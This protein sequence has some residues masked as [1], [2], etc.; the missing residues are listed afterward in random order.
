MKK[1]FLSSVGVMVLTIIHHIYGA[2][3]YNTAFRLHI[4]YFAIPVI[5]MLIFTY[6][7][8]QRRQT[9]WSGRI[10]FWLFVTI[11]LLIP[12]GGIGFIEGGFNH[13]VKNI[14]F[15]GGASQ[16]TLTHLFPPPKYEIPND[17]WFEATGILQFF[18]GIYPMYFFF[19]LWKEKSGHGRLKESGVEV[20][21]I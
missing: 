6:W 10:A 19:R 20:E 4:A 11:T 9:T 14:L 15:F 17:F 7:I 18:L 21:S 1:V 3:I 5:V 8:Y 12:V 2:I 16:S 13:L